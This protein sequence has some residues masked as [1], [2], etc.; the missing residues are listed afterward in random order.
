M[1][2]P[3]PD[4][5]VIAEKPRLIERLRAIVPGE[6]V[7]GEADE[8]RAFETDGLTAYRALP[9]CRR[10]PGRSRASSRCAPRWG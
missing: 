10:R 5:K 8:L 1:L 3:E 4:A 9:F 2:M 7:I 6:G